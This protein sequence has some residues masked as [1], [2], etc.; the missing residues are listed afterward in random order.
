M[1]YADIASI[2]KFIDSVNPTFL[3]ELEPVNSINS[4]PGY[5]S[6]SL[7]SQLLG[8]IIE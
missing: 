2:T 3:D 5:S 6:I 8:Y 4:T 7:F 1:L